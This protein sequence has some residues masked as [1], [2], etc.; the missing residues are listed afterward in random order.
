MSQGKEMLKAVIFD[1]NGVIINDE[2]IHQ[3]LI[4]EILLR[5]N[6]RP[7]PSEYQEL[8]LGRSDRACLSDILSRRGRVASDNYLD[9]LIQAKTLA[10]RQRIES[11]E[12]LPIYPE[13]KDFLSHLQEHNFRIGLVTGALLSEVQFILEK[14]EILNSFEVIVGGDEIKKSKPE[15]DGYLLAVE[16]FN[17]LDNSLQLTPKDCLV[18]EDTPTGIEAAKRAKMQ[19]V[20][21]ANT[22]P[23][24]FMQRLS[25]WAIDYFSELELERVEKVLT[26]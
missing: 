11:L 3:E 7:E 6:L 16:R 2:Q 23:Y 22:Y 13:V 25:N 9:D 18:I 1:F 10:Y 12:T 15:P 14:A 20:G 4:N 5:E 26:S 24:H 19:V 17:Q 8:C 21:I